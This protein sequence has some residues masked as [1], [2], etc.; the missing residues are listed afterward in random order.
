MH[1][2]PEG[3]GHRV[4]V[5]LPIR[6]EALI[7]G[8]RRRSVVVATRSAVALSGDRRVRGPS[9]Q[10]ED[11]DEGQDHEDETEPPEAAIALDS[12]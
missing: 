5:P 3:K 8:V 1:V 2:P 12:T 11:Q 4:P 10:R 9:V 7:P 6:V